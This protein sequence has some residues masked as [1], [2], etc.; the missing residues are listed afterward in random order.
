MKFDIHFLPAKYGDCIWIEYGPAGDT[1]NILIDGGTGGTKKHIRDMLKA[2]PGEK[3]VELLVVTHID[4]D[5]IEGIL[6]LLSEEELGFSVGSVWFNAWKHLP[7][8]ENEDE[9]FGARQG[10]LLS[11]AILKHGLNWNK[12]FEGGAIVLTDNGDIPVIL[13]PGGMKLT[14]LSPNKGNL[15]V[16]REKWEDELKKL[17]L[18]PGFGEEVPDDDID[19][20]GVDIPDIEQL[21]AEAFHEDEAAANGSSIAFLAEYGGERVLFAGDAFPSVVLNSLNKLYNEEVPLSL[22]KLSHHASAHNT[23]PE[24]I[25]KLDCKRF[26][27]STN[28]SIFKHPAQVTVARVIHLKGEGTE[29]IFNYKSDYNKCWNISS[30]KENYGY[31]TVYP[32]AEG[33]KIELL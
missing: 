1:K 18:V 19:S 7:R 23:S 2:L 29:L 16:L 26:V 30:L 31:S 6:S 8:P 27:I 14:L 9:E 28:G 15:S 5:H 25:E 10:E 11:A 4:K 17:D 22:V 21:A 32:S 20:F 12:E 33:I 13:L 3:E 24:L